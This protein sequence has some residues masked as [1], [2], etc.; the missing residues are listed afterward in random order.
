MSES[1]KLA[2]V[3]AQAETF[4]KE[5]KDYEA[6]QLFQSLYHRYSSRKNFPAGAQ[7]LHNGAL[8][9]LE[10]GQL[11]SG[12]EVALLLVECFTKGLFVADDSNIAT[13]IDIAHG[14]YSKNEKEKTVRGGANKGPCGK[15]MRAA[16]KWSQ[17]ESC[18]QGAVALHMTFA[19]MLQDEEEFSSAHSH[20]LR[21]GMP[22]EHARAM[23]E[24]SEHGYAS[25]RDLFLARCVFE[26]LCLEN[27][28]DANIVFRT[29]KT[30]C[31]DTSMDSPLV[32]FLQFL[33]LT[34]ERD[35]APLFQMLRQKYAVSLYR[36]ERNNKYLDRIGQLFFNIAAP[37]GILAGLLG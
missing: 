12:G 24:W 31:K 5:G 33:L 25:E 32:H 4:L 6:Q 37:K 34:C 9:L 2:K 26:Y 27:L 10:H 35:A 29:F 23:F 7:L 36:D 13:L 17:S 14:F 19:Q 15:F 28:K 18:P 20:Y 1:A 8:T 16:I 30:L 11:N 21:S 22:E 3:K